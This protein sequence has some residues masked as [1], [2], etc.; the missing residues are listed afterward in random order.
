MIGQAEAM[1]FYLANYPSSPQPQA[2]PP[3]TA[4]PT[5]TEAGTTATTATAPSPAAA[6]VPAASGTPSSAAAAVAA[7]SSDLIAIAT[8]AQALADKEEPGLAARLQSARGG[9]PQ[10]LVRAE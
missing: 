3:S 5:A 2:S 7:L 4:A 10:P 8:E 1:T 9:P 6:A